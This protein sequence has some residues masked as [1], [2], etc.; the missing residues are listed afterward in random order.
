[1]PSNSHNI[2]QIHNILFT[3]N[4]Q[5]L[6]RPLPLRSLPLLVGWGWVNFCLFTSGSHLCNCVYH[7]FILDYLH[8]KYPRLVSNTRSGRGMRCDEAPT[9]EVRSKGA[10][11]P[12][13]THHHKGGC[14]ETKWMR[15]VWRNGGMKF[16]VGD[17]GR[18]PEKNLP[19]PRFVHH[20]NS[21]GKFI[22]HR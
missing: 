2:L 10:G 1:M 19:W 6:P 17:N 9:L 11:R 13:L 16:V 21:H 20:W 8:I 4:E 5:T 12:H 3:L 14:N 15:W 22:F 7:G 18:N